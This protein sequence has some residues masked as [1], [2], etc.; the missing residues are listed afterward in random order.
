MLVTSRSSSS[1]STGSALCPRDAEQTASLTRSRGRFTFAPLTTRVY[2]K[3]QVLFHVFEESPCRQKPAGRLFE[4]GGTVG[5]EAP[6]AVGKLP[7]RVAA[8]KSSRQRQLLE[9]IAVRASRFSV[10][11]LPPSKCPDSS[12]R[13]GSDGC[14]AD[15]TEGDYRI[16]SF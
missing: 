6:T 2:A 4:A 15:C 14:A 3:K 9:P 7:E 10:N 8:V 13:P 5:P 11:G 1:S 12:K 16:G